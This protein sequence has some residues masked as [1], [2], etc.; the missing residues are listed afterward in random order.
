MN[1]YNEFDK[2][3][4]AWLRE[5]I[6]QGL[7][8]QG[9]VD[10]RSITEVQPD[11]I[12][13]YTQCHFF[14]GIGGWSRALQLAN[15]PTNRAVWTGSC[16]CQPYSSA[17]KNHG[18][19]DPRNLWPQFFRLIRQCKPDIVF[20][21]QVAS[22]IGHGWLD[23]ISADLESENYACGAIVLGAHSVGAP[24]IRQRLYWVANMQRKGLEGHGRLEQEPIQEGREGAQRY[25]SNG[26]TTL[27]LADAKQYGDR[28]KVDSSDNEQQK[29]ERSSD[30]TGGCCG[31]SV[32]LS[33][34]GRGSVD[35]LEIAG[36]DGTGSVTGKTGGQR[37]ESVDAGTESIRQ[38][39]GEA[40]TSGTDSRSP[41]C[42]GGLGNTVCNGKC[43]RDGRGLGEGRKQVGQSK[44]GESP[45]NESGDGCE[46]LD[47]MGNTTS[48]GQC[49]GSENL[50]NQPTEMLGQRHEGNFWSKFEIV[51][52]RDGKARRFESQPQQMADGIPV[53][54]DALRD[55][56]VSE[57]EI[58]TAC[59]SFPLS[60]K[61]IAGRAGLLKG[62]GNAIVPQGAAQ[63]ILAL[64]EVAGIE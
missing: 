7:I 29:T 5:L 61:R 17:G 30:R 38:G 59:S 18:D 14:A 36:D 3:A 25:G 47:R 48:I 55:V 40:G 43:G 11:E 20:G 24:H 10:E 26:G 64:K 22:A 52:C 51:Q 32:C 62:F 37:G 8:P 33:D 58:A 44:D 4:A 28:G 31:S 41:S 42:A 6:K 35:G 56:G 60:A 45:A 1:Y 23:G 39:H 9:D 63:F 57:D 15:W 12:K 53:I 46:E 16:P 49:G 27:R 21:E 54:L 19:K 2:K 13:K 34:N 50:I